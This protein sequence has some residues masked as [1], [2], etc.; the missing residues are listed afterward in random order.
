M[1]TDLGEA[2]KRIGRDEGID[3]IMVSVGST[4]VAEQA[5]AFVRKGGSINLFAGLPGSARITIDPRRIHYDEVTLLGSFGFGPNH[6]RRAAEALAGGT[7]DVSG[8]FT[9][10][11]TL[12]GLEAALADAASYRGIKSALVFA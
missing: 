11:V 3:K 7:L 12:A 1:Q 4:E 9:G 5:F 2:V 8:F 6:F 10:V